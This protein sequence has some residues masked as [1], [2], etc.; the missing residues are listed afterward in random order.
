M[1]KHPLFLIIPRSVP[2]ES[3]GTA[4]VVNRLLDNFQE[5]EFILL[6]RSP[7]QKV[8]IDKQIKYTHYPIPTTYIRGQR[9]WRSVSIFFGLFMGIYVVLKHRPKYIIGVYPNE[10]SLVLSYLLSVVTG[11]KLLTY[12]CDL[13][14]ENRKSAWGKWLSG[15]IQR[16]VFRRSEKIL[17][18]NAGM[19][20]YYQERYGIDSL[21]IPTPINAAVR[22][23]GAVPSFN[24]NKP[25]VIGYSGSINKDRI[26]PFQ[27]FMKAAAKIQG[28]DIQFKLL[29][30]HD[31][32]LLQ[33]WDMEYPNTVTKFCRSFD[34]LM[35]ELKECHLLYL[36]LTFRT[37]GN[38]VDQL[39]TCFGIKAYEYILSSKPILVHCPGNYFTYTFF[40]DHDAAFLIDSTDIEVVKEKLLKVLDSYND[41]AQHIVKQ[42]SI[43]GKQ[44]EGHAVADRLRT[45]LTRDTAMA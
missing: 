19:Q 39:A 6:A 35:K 5:D 25:F 17:V 10:S 11:K 22:P 44:F 9:F 30:P 38:A 40:A 45:Y 16:N 18:V 28:Y 31:K 33:S 14:H 36:P 3:G 12:Y 29:G 32:A 27:V 43:Q 23:N 37:D 4:I 7:Y 24:K 8:K 21:L 15:L 20:K 34:E 13:Y 41:Q 26:D 42:A 2:V 1:S